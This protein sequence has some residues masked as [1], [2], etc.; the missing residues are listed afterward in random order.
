MYIATQ[1][2]DME[3]KEKLAR[4][5]STAGCQ[6]EKEDMTCSGCHALEG[7]NDKM[8]GECPMRKCGMEKKLSHCAECGEYPCSHIEGLVPAGSGNRE[9]LDGFSRDNPRIL[10]SKS[11]L[12]GKG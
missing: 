12:D 10:F 8:C 6:F 5:Y 2:G 9:T 4:E 1:T 7:T 3:L 11:Y